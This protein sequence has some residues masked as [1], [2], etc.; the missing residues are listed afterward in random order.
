MHSSAL[1]GPQARHQG[2][3]CAKVLALIVRLLS[4]LPSRWQLHCAMRA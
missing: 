1:G 2:A 3:A 4:H